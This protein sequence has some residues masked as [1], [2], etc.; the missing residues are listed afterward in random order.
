MKLDGTIFT[1]ERRSISGCIDMAVVFFRE[2]FKPLMTLTLLF[3]VPCCVFDYWIASVTDAGM[4]LSL[5]LFLAVT[6][7]FSSVLVAG[8]GR[9]VFGERLRV[10]QALRIVV[11]RLFFAS[12]V[13]L[14]CRGVTVFCG[15]LLLFPA[16]LV[17]ARYGFLAEILFLENV[18]ARQYERRLSDFSSA[19]GNLLVRMI[20]ISVFYLTVVI[21]L[22]ALVDIA[23]GILFGMPVLFGRVS[24][25]PYAFDDFLDLLFYDPRVVVAWNACLWMAFPIARL[26]WFFCY[27]DSRTRQECWDIELDFRVEA[28]RLESAL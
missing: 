17:A 13:M 20:M 22:Y 2:H 6:P 5:L 8:S 18:P 3:A 27:L 14:I 10:R 11:S 16:Y 26:A 7:F 23:S 28:Q 21:S 15:F 12:M 24:S 9:R 25:G 19:Y 4:V 1:I